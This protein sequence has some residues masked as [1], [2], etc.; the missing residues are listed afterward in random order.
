M[1]I[2][3]ERRR[4]MHVAPSFAVENHLD[5]LRYALIKAQI[6]LPTSPIPIIPAHT[7]I[8]VGF[9]SEKTAIVSGMAAMTQSEI[10]R[11]CTSHTLF[12]LF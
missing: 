10:N 7:L 8:T 2:G 5:R 11:I 12:D 9:I 3:M 4:T 1:G 6:I